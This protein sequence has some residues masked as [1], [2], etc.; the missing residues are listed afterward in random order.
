MPSLSIYIPFSRSRGLLLRL[1][2]IL[3]RSKSKGRT[4]ARGHAQLPAYLRQDVGLLPEIERPPPPSHR[5]PF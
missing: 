4:R 1:A 5:F 2:A 3:I